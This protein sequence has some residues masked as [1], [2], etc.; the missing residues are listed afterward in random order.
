VDASTS[1]AISMMGALCVLVLVVSFE[2]LR[3]RERASR[4]LVRMGLIDAPTRGAP[5]GGRVAGALVLRRLGSGLTRWWSSARLRELRSALA[6]AGVEDS[7]GVESYLALRVAAVL[8]GAL[9]GVL[10]FLTMQALAPLL[11]LGP[12]AGYLL[13]P[14]LLARLAQGRRRAIERALPNTLDMIMVSLEAG[15]TFDSAVLLLC[16][17]GD[18]ALLRELRRYLSDTG[19]GRSR[20]EALEAL[21]ERVQSPGVNQFV[22]ALVQAQDLGTGL[23]RTLRSQSRALREVRRLAAEERARQATVKL[24]FPLVLCIMPVLFS[25][26]VGPAVLQVLAVFQ[27]K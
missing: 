10:A 8:V 21:A 3:A 27:G 25:L 24:L 18:N 22:A 14:V 4:R 12:V 13:P 7:L 17:R 16:R 6:H 9:G 2:R 26:I 23:A 19:F 11:V 5:V 1:V 20:R 15:L